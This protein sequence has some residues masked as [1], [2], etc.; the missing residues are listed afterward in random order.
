MTNVVLRDVAASDLDVFFEHERD[1]QA[2]QM[3]AFT[4]KEPQDRAAFDSHWQKIMADEQ[5]FNQTIM[6][7]GEVAGSV[8][9]FMAFGEREIT[10][11]IGREYWGQGIASRALGLFLERIRERP[12]FARAA[13]ENLGSIRVLEKNGFQQVGEERGF[14]NARGEEIAEVVFRLDSSQY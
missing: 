10:Y 1:P 4:A 9:T 11:W 12:L 14:A 5:I 13:K 6:V 7:D 3:A 8:A 2:Y